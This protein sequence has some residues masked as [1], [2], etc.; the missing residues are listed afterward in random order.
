[1]VEINQNNWLDYSKWFIQPVQNSTSCHIISD[2]LFDLV[3]LFLSDEEFFKN[4]IKFVDNTFKGLP[5]YKEIICEL[6]NFNNTYGTTPGIDELFMVLYNKNY[7]EIGRKEELDELY[8]LLKQRE[9]TESRITFLKNSF[10]YWNSYATLLQIM[11]DIKL[12]TE[13]GFS[14]Y[15]Q[16]MNFIN[17]ITDKFKYVE[18]SVKFIKKADENEW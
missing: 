14:N 9:L 12:Q 10:P 1:M 17:M 4:N 11:S 3:K 8:E 18:N 2:Y 7:D 6:K 16:Y 13:S 5:L 15:N